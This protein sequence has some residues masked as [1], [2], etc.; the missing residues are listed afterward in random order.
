MSWSGKETLF[1]GTLAASGQTWGTTQAPAAGDGIKVKSLNFPLGAPK[2]D[3]VPQTDIGWSTYLN[4]GNVEQIEFAIEP[5]V[6]RYCSATT[7][8]PLDE[9]L[10]GLLYGATTATKTSATYAYLH[11]GTIASNHALS[12][13]VNRWLTL[14]AQYKKDAGTYTYLSMPSWQPIGFEWS[15]EAGNPVKVSIKGIANKVERDNSTVSGAFTNITYLDTQRAV[16][17]Y[18]LTT[19]AT[20][21]IWVAQASPEGSAAVT[22][23]STCLVH[24]QSVSISF[25]RKMEATYTDSRYSDAPKD[26][27]YAEC[28][29]KMKFA[30]Y[31]DTL[32]TLFDAALKAWETATSDSDKKFYHFRGRW[33]FPDAIESTFFPY[34]EIGIPKLRLTNVTRQVE[35]GKIISLEAEFDALAPQSSTNLPACFTQVGGSAGSAFDVLYIAI[36]S[37]SQ[38]ALIA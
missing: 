37:K 33:V 11:T 10:M 9:A 23:D 4:E 36:Q 17:H 7:A 19:D 15:S 20:A 14:A 34:Y 16:Q 12:N 28:K 3:A 18:H 2:V 5:D 6:F 21:G 13:T 24:P 27:G 30:Y 35:A 31:T 32:E 22:F 25:S 26:N 29:V 8:S 1:S 38:T